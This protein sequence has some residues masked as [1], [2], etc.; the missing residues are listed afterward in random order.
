MDD[1]DEIRQAIQTLAGPRPVPVGA[2][3]RIVGRVAAK[4]R[5][6]LLGVA[7]ATAALIGVVVVGAALESPERKTLPPT[8]IEKGPSAALFVNTGPYGF[9]VELTVRFPDNRQLLSGSSG[10]TARTTRSSSITTGL[11]TD[12]SPTRS[13]WPLASQ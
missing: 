12:P 9:Y 3:D 10:R 11:T 13:R 1:D 7:A 8:R 4:R 2:R 5:R 6:R